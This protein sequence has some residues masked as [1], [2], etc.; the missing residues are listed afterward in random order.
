MAG[1]AGWTPIAPPPPPDCAPVGDACETGED[2]CSRLCDV[3]SETCVSQL[4]ICW[5]A[6]Q[7]CE[8][9]TDCCSLS[10]V[11][12]VCAAEG[13]LSDGQ[14]CTSGK[15]CCSGTCDTTCVPLNLDC[16][17]SGNA[18]TD[19]SECCSKLCTRGVCQIGSSYCIQEGDICTD[20]NDCCNGICVVEA[21]ATVGTCGAPPPAPAN[22]TGVDGTVCTDC[23]DCCSALCVPYGPSGVLVCQPA[24]GCRVTGELCREDKDCCG[25]DVDSG[26]PGA[27]NVQCDKEDGAAVGRCNNGQ[28]CTP[29]GGVCHYKEYA[30]AV[31][32][33][34]AACCGATGA[35]SGAC[36]LDT[37]GVPRCFPSTECTIEGDI[38][39]ATYDCCGGVCVP[40]AAGTLRCTQPPD[41][42]PCIPSGGP[43]TVNADCCPPTLCIR[44]PGSASGYCGILEPPSTGGAP[45]TGGAP[46]TGGAGEGGEPP[47]GGTSGTGGQPA[48][49]GTPATGGIPIPVCSEYGQTC[50]VASDCC[51]D[52]PCTAG[53]CVYPF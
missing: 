35:S 46:A 12:G 5:G 14:D 18:C 40:D 3:A 34:N 17:T 20:D 50:S 7:G 39:S 2:C 13:C 38:C 29:Q 26:L 4:N 52:V 21:D 32:S 6:G 33:K 43:C 49:G 37:I 9:A 8:V 28:S 36:Q 10:C 25:G 23:G 11:D 16:K 42:G 47:T 53:R 44:E 22:C 45:G 15:Q 51:N 24:S 31:S 27:G 48:T 19:S 1:A 41:E 30:C